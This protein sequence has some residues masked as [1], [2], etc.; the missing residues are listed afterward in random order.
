V[1]PVPVTERTESTKWTESVEAHEAKRSALLRRGLSS[2]SLLRKS[3]QEAGKTG[4]L[5]TTIKA[6]KPPR[7]PGRRIQNRLALLAAW[8]FTPWTVEVLIG[9]LRGK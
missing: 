5:R 2:F 7:P 1:G 4:R 9:A 3:E 6:A 8:R